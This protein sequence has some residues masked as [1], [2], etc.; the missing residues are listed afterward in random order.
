MNIQENKTLF[1]KC[2]QKDYTPSHAAE[3]G[4]YL[5]ETSNI[6]DYIKQGVRSMLIE[7]DLKTVEKIKAY[8][9]T[10]ADLTIHPVAI[11]DYTGTLVL[12]NRDAS[13]F[14]A[15]LKGSPALINDKYTIKAED[16]FEVPC[17]TFDTIDDGSIDLLSVDIEGGEWFVLK[18][19]KSRPDVISIETHGKKYINPFIQEILDWMDKHNYQVWYKDKSDTVFVKEGTFEITPKEKSQLFWTEFRLNL[20]RMRKKIGL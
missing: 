14:A 12:V 10:A 5:P 13:T 8:F 2:N 20:R 19:M 4:V 7:P 3:V 16:K 11:Y 9:K 15:D 1:K 6:V 17:T 18:H